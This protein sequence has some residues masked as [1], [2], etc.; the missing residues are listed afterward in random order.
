ME[1][2]IIELWDNEGYEY[3]LV[4][5]RKG[6]IEAFKKE[7]EKYREFDEYNFDDFLEIIKLKHWFVGLVVPKDTIFF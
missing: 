7:L 6:F 4:E 2:E 3:P 1:T 5:V